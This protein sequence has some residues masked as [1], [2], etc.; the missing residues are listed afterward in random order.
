LKKRNDVGCGTSCEIGGD[1]GE[2][3]GDDIELD[4]GDITGFET[5][6]ESSGC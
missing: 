4:T 5:N 2:I 1:T 6:C 3:R